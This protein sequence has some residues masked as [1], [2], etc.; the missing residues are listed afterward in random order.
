MIEHRSTAGSSMPIVPRLTHRILCTI[1]FALT[2]ILAGCASP[3][4]KPTAAPAPTGAPVTSEAPLSLIPAPYSLRRDE[5]YFEVRDGMVLRVQAEEDDLAKAAE[6]L[7]ETVLRSRGLHLIVERPDPTKP[8]RGFSEKA[9]IDL[10]RQ[11]I[12]EDET[13]SDERYT[14]TVSDQ[15][16]EIGAHAGHGFFN[17][18]TTLWQLLTLDGKTSGP[19]RVPCLRIEDRP[20]FAWRGL[21]LDSARHFQPPEYVKQ[22]IDWMALHKYNVLHWHLTDDQGWRIEIKRYPK[23]TEVGAWRTPAGVATDSANG[24]PERIG[25]Y[26]TQAQIRDIVA[27]AQRRYVTIVPEIEMPGHAQA[28]IAA[29]PQL[30]IDGRNPGVSHDWGVHTQLYNVEDSTFVFLQNVLTET[31]ALFPSPYIH[32]G[33]DEAAKDRWQA[34]RRVQQRMHALGLNNE[35]QMQSWFI[36]RIEKFLSAHGRKL[37]GWD[38]ILEG[39]L[40]PQATVMSWRGIQGA[41]D[42][43]KQGHDVVLSPDPDLYINHHATDLAEEPAGRPGAVT[44]RGVYDFDPVPKQLSA[45]EVR[46]VLGAQANLWSEYLATPASIT[47]AAWPRAAA[48][49]EVLWS[50]A[51]AHDWHGFLHRLVPQLERYRTLGLDYGQ[52]PFAVDIRRDYDAKTKQVAI[53]LSNQVAFGEIRYTLDG[54]APSAQS[55]LYRSPF[56]VPARGEI[57][58]TAFARDVAL[59]DARTRVLTPQALLQR[60]SAELAPCRSDGLVL[61][62]PGPATYGGPAKA[63]SVDLFESCR[64]WKQADLDGIARIDVEAASLPYNFQL[65]HD[66]TRIVDRKPEKF[67][68]GE[69]QVRIDGCDGELLAAAPIAPLLASPRGARIDLEFA[70]RSGKHDLCLRFA[71]GAHDPLHVIDSVQ[72]VPR[73]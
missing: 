65:W 37:V 54:S 5:G 4:V 55:T 68:A 48:L 40:P 60:A 64:L 72:L 45:A 29:Y 41:V 66:V 53:D 47:R 21:M 12:G 62:L 44:L 25:G 14:L 51:S 49:A 43:A 13:G 69:L 32:I 27:Y 9:G 2:A 30:G 38:E 16:I 46:H 1:A 10:R 59:A 24:K 31:M 8:N 70:P 15:G 35:A 58:A 26:Y 50:P 67:P 22:F 63:Y 33:G 11:W 36:K 7:S 71:T 18:A 20:R 28:A 23:L 34:S 56:T 3:A 57:R 39:G 61:K 42:A 19:A 52:T 17:A 6:W 73:P